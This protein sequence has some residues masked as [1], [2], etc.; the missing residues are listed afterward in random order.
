M[1]YYQKNGVEARIFLE[2]RTDIFILFHGFP[3][4][5]SRQKA[6][7]DRGELQLENN[8]TAAST[9]IVGRADNVE[10]R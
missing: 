10:L 8:S 4:R 1:H 7:S 5:H 3:V 9:G 6:H 2:E